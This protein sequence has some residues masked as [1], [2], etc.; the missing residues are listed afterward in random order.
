MYGHIRGWNLG[1]KVTMHVNGEDEDVV[2][3]SL[4]SGSNGYDSGLC[5]GSFTK[6]DLEKLR[7]GATYRNFTKDALDFARMF[8]A[9]SAAS[10]VHGQ[11]LQMEM[12]EKYPHE[13]MEMLHSMIGE[14]DP[15]EDT[16]GREA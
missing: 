5:L 6:E 14:F 1:G 9:L 12:R 3:V 13:W 10:T 11:E 8:Y 7:A 15:P 2:S 16:S 4:T